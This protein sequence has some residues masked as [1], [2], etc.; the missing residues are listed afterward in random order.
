M[1][2][3]R[4]VWPENDSL[5]VPLTSFSRDE[6]VE[7]RKRNIPGESGSY[8]GQKARVCL[9]RPGCQMWVED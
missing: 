7:Q 1:G 2:K 4:L 3:E 9:G 6:D 5:A 8:R